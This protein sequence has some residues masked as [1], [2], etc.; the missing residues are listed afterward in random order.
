VGF[1]LAM[2]AS[3]VDWY[4]RCGASRESVYPFCYVVEPAP[5]APT[6]DGSQAEALHF[7][8]LYIG[9]FVER[10]AVD[11][12]LQALAGLRAR[13]WSAVLIGSGP[14][15]SRIR[16]MVVA[17]G[18]SNRVRIYPAQPRAMAMQMLAHADVLVLP[19][20]Y[21]GWGAVVNE[22]LMLGVPVVCTSGCGASDLI[23]YDWLGS[24]VAPGSV[25]T[26]SAALDKR[27]QDGRLKSLQR[28]KIRTWARC[29]DGPN[30]ALYFTAVLNH[31]YNEGPRPT[32]PWRQNCRNRECG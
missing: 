6:F 13:E 17:L 3:G 25:L 18:L 10:K 8:I 26:M 23:R 30:I 9:Q 11:V 16:R 1:T 24:V 12:L 31:V 22:A 20:N 7:Q 27:L 15:E 19:S 4:A 28:E 32:P 14:L 21:D 29:V 5:A 2:G